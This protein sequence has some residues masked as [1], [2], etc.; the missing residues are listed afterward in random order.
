M[1]VQRS[2]C[3]EKIG[4]CSTVG[5]P[6]STNHG[7]DEMIGFK[8]VLQRLIRIPPPSDL[9]EHDRADIA[10]QVKSE[11]RVCAAI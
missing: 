2:S 6:P 10:L 8:C 4:Q 11:G 1:L 9:D 7:P 5:H 3:L